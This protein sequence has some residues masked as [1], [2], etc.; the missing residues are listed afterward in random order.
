MNDNETKELF[1]GTT[2]ALIESEQAKNLTVPLTKSIGNTLGDICDIAF[3]RIGEAAEKSRLKHQKNIDDFKKT[4]YEDLNNIPEENRQEPKAS[5]VGPALEAS[6][7]Y[8]DE[9]TI[10]SMFEKL[11][12]N[13]MDNRKASKVHPSF[14]EIIKQLSPLDAQTLMCFSRE[15]KLPICQ[16]KRVDTSNN[17]YNIAQTNVFISNANCQDISLQS[18]SISSLNRLGLINVDY[19]LHLSDKNRYSA[20][21]ELDYYKSLEFSLFFF[22]KGYKMEIENGIASLTPLGKTFIEICLSPLPK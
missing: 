15:D 13:S 16:F 12:V 8:Y 20:F 6:K 4:L 17:S 22:P 1:E 21:R 2:K 10:R 11:I 19:N 5:I 18:I 9:E 7:Y 3:G 14:T